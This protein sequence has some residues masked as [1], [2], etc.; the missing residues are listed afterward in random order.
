M[1]ITWIRQ[2]LTQLSG[3]S[4]RGG[5]APLATLIRARP[6]LSYFVLTF[7]ISW[8]GVLILAV[9]GGIPAAR[10]RFE[11]LLPFAVLAMIAGPS[12]AS[13]LFTH[14]VHGRAGL[15][16]LR[17]RLLRWRVGARW[18][19]AALLTAPIL[20]TAVLLPLSFR[21]REFL[22]G[23]AST[24]DKASLVLLGIVVA[25]AAGVFEELGW[26]GFAVPELRRRYG[27]VTTGLIVGVP[28]GAW[29]LLPG[30]WG[31]G[32]SAGSLS[33]GLFLPSVVSALGV[34][35]AYR[36]LMVWVYD[37]TR[38]L[39]VA[40]LMHASLTAATLIL[41]PQATGLPLLTFTLALAAMLWVVVAVIAVR[42][43][44]QLSRPRQPLRNRMA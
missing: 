30:F 21:S 33:I 6:V 36:V 18:H 31:S 13:I 7:G 2:Y 32:D 27:I 35:P 20:T 28:W 42:K 25:L 41:Q 9:P 44:G 12:V 40:M 34:L 8:G 3:Q 38:S 4:S 37:H 17:C 11:A 26:T 29:H 22:P 14:I 10:E 16:E 24:N 19:A 23:I 15:R 39:L 43:G 5:E 1:T